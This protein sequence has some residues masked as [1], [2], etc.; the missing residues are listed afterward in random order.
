MLR[1]TWQT[2]SNALVQRVEAVSRVTGGVTAAAGGWVH[3]T[4]RRA[5]VE[6]P[7]TTIRVVAVETWQAAAAA[8]VRRAVA[9]PVSNY[10]AVTLSSAASPAQMS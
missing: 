6:E 9:A 3:P 10:A 2:G 8:D 4:T 1:L 5:H 7:P